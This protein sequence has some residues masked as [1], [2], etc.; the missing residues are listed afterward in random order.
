MDSLVYQDIEI[1]QSHLLNEYAEICHGFST[2]E[3]GVSRAKFATLNLGNGRGDD[4]D[5]IKENTR[6][7]CKAVKISPHKLVHLGQI[8]S[9]NIAKVDRPGFIENT[10]GVITD[11]E[12]IFLSV[13][14][15]D[16]VPVLF[17]TPTAKV[18]G[19]LHMGWRGIAKK[20]VENF[21]EKVVENYNVDPANLLVAIGPSIGK[22]CYEVKEDV[23]DRFDDS[24]IISKNNKFFLDL[25][26]AV[27]NRLIK[28]GINSS[29]IDIIELCTYCNPDRFFS[30]RRD[31]KTTGSML[32]FIGLKNKS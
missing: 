17:Y 8:H 18:V 29:K 14:T 6:R 1:L 21:I 26:T 25:D 24:E 22:C 10:D 9:S 11:T 20:I 16:C 15:A 32:S 23:L 2:R 4:I 13:K 28:L 7:F 5:N 19:A 12:G 27:V 3:G 30:Y 31:G